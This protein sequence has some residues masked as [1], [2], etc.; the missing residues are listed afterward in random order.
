MTDSLVLPRSARRLEKEELFPLVKVLAV[1]DQ[2][3][4]LLVGLDL[5][6]DVRHRL[7]TG[8]Q[9]GAAARRLQQQ[10]GDQTDGAQE[11][12]CLIMRIHAKRFTAVA[13]SPS[14]T[15][16]NNPTTRRTED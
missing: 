10:H 9:S 14:S 7:C 4:D 3:H 15:S 13:D 8:W 11:L 5:S 16:A 1:D 12:H 6:S 2:R